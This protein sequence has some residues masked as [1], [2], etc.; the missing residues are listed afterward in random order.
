MFRICMHDAFYS[1][2]ARTN[3]GSFFRRTNADKV[4]VKCSN[5]FLSNNFDLKNGASKRNNFF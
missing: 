1:Q 4:I 3:S 5:G 2:H